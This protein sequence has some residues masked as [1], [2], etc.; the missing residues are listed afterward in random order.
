MP[1]D[2][3]TIVNPGL[4]PDNNGVYHLSGGSSAIGVSSGNYP[5]VTTD[6][7]GNPRGSSPDTGADQFATIP[8]KNRP[9]TVPD[10]GPGAVS[11]SK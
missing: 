2:S 8:V 9:L 3:F 1:A 5:F 6:I 4:V 11:M 10:V 7:D